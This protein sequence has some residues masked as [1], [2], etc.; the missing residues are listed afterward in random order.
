V[1]IS[2]RG[3]IGFLAAPAII[4]VA[5]LM[6]VKAWADDELSGFG[7]APV[8]NAG[9]RWQV[10]ERIAILGNPDPEL[11]GIIERGEFEAWWND[12]L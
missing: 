6:P 1:N 3:F 5:T 11:R 12:G 8:K 4:R 7:L 9:R 10:T 2:R